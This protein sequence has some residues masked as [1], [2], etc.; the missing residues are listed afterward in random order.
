MTYFKI[1]KNKDENVIVALL[2]WNFF[3]I[4]LIEGMVDILVAIAETILLMA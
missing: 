3:Y 4:L 1:K 2:K